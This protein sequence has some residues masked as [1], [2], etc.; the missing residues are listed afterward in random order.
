MHTKIVA[1]LGNVHIRQY[2]ETDTCFNMN[3]PHK[4][5]A[6]LKKKKKRTQATY[7]TNNTI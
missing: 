6:E 7:S 4:L 3:K 5:Y 1:Y 2:E